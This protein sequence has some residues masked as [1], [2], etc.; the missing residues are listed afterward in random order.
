M[1][2]LTC[3]C[4]LRHYFLPF[5]RMRK[6]VGIVLSIF[7]TIIREAPMFQFALEGALFT[8]KAKSP[9]LAPLFTLPPRISHQSKA[10][11]QSLIYSKFLV[12]N[13]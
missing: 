4:F 3:P 2:S 8:L 6:R 5:A 11:S 1:L 7:F 10:P 13:F 12:I 9:A